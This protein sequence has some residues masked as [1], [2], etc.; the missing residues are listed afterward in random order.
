MVDSKSMAAGSRLPAEILEQIVDEISDD[1]PGSGALYSQQITKTKALLA[2]STVSRAWNQV[3]QPLLYGSIH[4]FDEKNLCS[5]LWQ[6]SRAL[7]SNPQLAGLVR[8]LSVYVYGP[9]RFQEG[10]EHPFAEIARV[11]G[12]C[13][14]LTKLYF[15]PDQQVGYQHLLGILEKCTSIEDLSVSRSFHINGQRLRPMLPFL[16]NLRKLDIEGISGL[17]DDCLRDIAKMC[18]LLEHLDLQRTHITQINVLSVMKFA[19]N[20]KSLNISECAE[21]TP[22]ER[23][24]IMAEKP[25][26]VKIIAI[27]DD[28]V[29][30]NFWTDPDRYSD[31]DEFSDDYYL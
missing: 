12:L 1:E 5:K 25:P 13:P 11:A 9:F 22:L 18:P 30:S 31:D 21:I 28:S 4:C 27:Y 23:E 10:A 17:D 19:T 6:L 29:D 16:K 20:L 2:L 15:Q 14:N 3:A 8:E 24:D 7:E 26:H